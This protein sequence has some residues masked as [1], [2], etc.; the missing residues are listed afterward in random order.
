MLRGCYPHCFESKGDSMKHVYRSVLP[1][2]LVAVVVLFLAA[3]AQEVE[4]G[5]GE[6]VG[7]LVVGMPGDPRSLDPQATNDQPSARVMKQIYDT[8]LY[9]TPDLDVTTNGLA[10]SY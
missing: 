9:Q 6:D 4:D 5:K 8:L 10:E 2:V 3:C 7:T 1:L